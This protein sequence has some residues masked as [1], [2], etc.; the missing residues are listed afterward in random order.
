M[1]KLKEIN[2]SIAISVSL[3]LLTGVGFAKNEIHQPLPNT[4]LI[5]IDNSARGLPIYSIQYNAN[6]NIIQII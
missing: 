3:L 4:V 6:F 2:Y 5:N 1:P